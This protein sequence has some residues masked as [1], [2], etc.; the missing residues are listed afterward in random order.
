MSDDIISDG[1]RY[2]NSGQLESYLKQNGDAITVSASKLDEHL[3]NWGVSDDPRKWLIAALIAATPRS[4]GKT[5]CDNCGQQKRKHLAV[6]DGPL[7]CP[8]SPQTEFAPITLESA[9]QVLETLER[10]QEQPRRF[11]ETQVKEAIAITIRETRRFPFH[12][13]PS[14]E[15]AETAFDNISRKFDAPESEKL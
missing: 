9:L 7:L 1:E 5:R 8:S 13:I 10:A 15:L 12:K 4:N 11:T 3:A 6:E 14:A 2:P